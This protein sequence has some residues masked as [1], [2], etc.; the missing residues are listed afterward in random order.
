MA[1]LEDATE[2]DAFERAVE[3]GGVVIAD[4]F[5]PQCVICRRVHPMLAAVQAQFR[6]RISAFKID[7][8]RRSDLATRYDV[9]GVP[10]LLL[11]NDGQLLARHSGFMTATALREWVTPLVE[12]KALAD[13]R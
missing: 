13:R 7:A 4:F 10:H 1:Q 5:T 8:E 11:F 9:R 3:T 6:G 12:P 2:G